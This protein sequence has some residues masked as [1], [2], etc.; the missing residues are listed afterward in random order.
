MLHKLESVVM[1]R[2]FLETLGAPHQTPKNRKDAL[3]I[4]YVL[5]FARLIGQNES[6]N[7]THTYVYIF[8]HTDSAIWIL[9]SKM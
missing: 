6:R 5:N 3:I 9:K 4:G 2:M 7:L 8:C 1:A